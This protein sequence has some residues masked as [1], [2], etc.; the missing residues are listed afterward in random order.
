MNFYYKNPRPALVIESMG[1]ANLGRC[2]NSMSYRV[3]S[4]EKINRDNLIK[5][6]DAGFLGYG[7][8]FTVHSQCDGKEEPGGYDMI[9]CHTYNSQ[10]HDLGKD[11][12]R[13]PIKVS[14]F[15]YNCESRVDS[16]D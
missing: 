7:Q 5:L 1:G 4:V 13:Q 11:E 8:E 6:R 12:S 16:S 9:D 10:G 15:I 14:Y 3:T 2:Y